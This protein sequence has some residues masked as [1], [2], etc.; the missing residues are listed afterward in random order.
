MLPRIWAGRIA[1]FVALFIALALAPRALTAQPPTMKAHFINVG[2]AASALLEFSCG[3]VLIDAGA[4]DE[5]HVE[6][7]AEYLHAF[8]QRRTDLNN[9]LACVFITHPHIDHTRGLRRVAQVCRIA[10]YVDGGLLTGSGRHEV[11]WI[12]REVAEGRMTTMIRP[13]SHAEVVALPQRRGLSDA[14]IDPLNCDDLN[15]RI[16]ILHAS[17]ATNPGW[18]ATQFNNENNHSLV[19]RVDFGQ[20]SFLFTGDLQEQGINLLLNHFRGTQILDVDVLHVGHHGSHNATTPG[21]LNAVT[22][23]AAVIGVGRWDFGLADPDVAQGFNTHNFGHPRRDVVLG[24]TGAIGFTRTSPKQVR[25]FRGARDPVRFTVRRN[26]YGTGWDGDVIF[27][28]TS[29][30]TLTVSTVST[31]APPVGPMGVAPRAAVAGLP[32]PI[33]SEDGYVPPA[34]YDSVPDEDLQSAPAIAYSPA[35]TARSPRR[36][37]IFR[38]RCRPMR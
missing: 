12:R 25:V 32:P 27:E 16:R 38:W 9:T 22:P 14:T 28:A 31:P 13:V 15:P 34:P 33:P 35:Y 19:I 30:G 10:R 11:R 37:A 26:I 21:L 1:V 5:D 24:L 20:S 3:A 18:S 6:H 23:E 29:L 36:W 7:L 8:F 17:H 4:Q 2:Q